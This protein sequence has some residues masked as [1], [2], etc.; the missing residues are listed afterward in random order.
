MRLIVRS[1]PLPK[2]KLR[3]YP[4]LQFIELDGKPEYAV[5]PYK[6]YKR[7]AALAEDTEDVRAFDKARTSE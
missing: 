2:F 3:H 1:Y 4:K 6:E 5:I 7:L